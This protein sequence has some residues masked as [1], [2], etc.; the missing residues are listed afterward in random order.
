M[1]KVTLLFL[2]RDG[3]ILLAMKKRGFGQ[4]HWNGAGGKVDP[5][6]TV[7]QAA[8]RECREEIGVTP[9]DIAPAGRLAFYI[10]DDP[11]FEGHDM[12]VFTATRW[13]GNPHETEEMRPQWFNM[14]DI[15]YE[16]MWA[17]DP[18]WL[19]HLL[20]GKRFA[21]SITLTKAGG[22]VNIDIQVES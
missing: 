20:A 21:G 13:A 22:I 6:E 8:V 18:H 5:G 7:E 11:D 12:H 16:S 2:L 10:S 4:G 1:K 19:P 15:P 9:L 14:T 17:D 3:Q